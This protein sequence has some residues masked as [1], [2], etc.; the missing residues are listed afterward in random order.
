AEADIRERR[1]EVAR[2]EQ[3]ISQREESLERRMR[4]LEQSEQRLTRREEELEELRLTT[5]SERGLVGRELE[6]VAGLSQLEARAEL[7]AEVESELDTEV[8]ER[9]RDADRRVRE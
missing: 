5:E 9:I 1:A 3:R 2:L 7:L 4:E 6:R 8:A